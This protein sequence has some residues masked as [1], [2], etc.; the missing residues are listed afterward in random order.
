M[1]AFSAALSSFG[2]LFPPTWLP[3]A[4]QYYANYEV[5]GVEVGTSTVE[6]ASDSDA[7]ETYG[8]GPWE[9]FL[10]L[11]CGPYVVPTV[12]LELRLATELYR[13]RPDRYVPLIEYL[14]EQGCDRGLLRRAM[15]AGRLSEDLGV[16]VLNQLEGTSTC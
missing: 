13:Q 14:R 16:D 9:H 5:R 7:I 4:R 3:D 15:Q 12:A 2:C 6:V 8:C 10:L 11:P 1:D